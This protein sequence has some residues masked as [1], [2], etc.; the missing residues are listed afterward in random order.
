MADV[1]TLLSSVHGRDRRALRQI[2]K[3][4][5]R[6]AVQYGSR[7]LQNHGY[8]PRYRYTFANIVYITDISSRREITSYVLPMHKV[9]VS[10]LDERIHKE[11]AESL[12]TLPHSSTS[13]CILIVDQSGSMRTCDVV[14]HKTRSD[15]VFGCIALDL[16]GRQI[17]QAGT[18]LT[19]AVTLIEMR[20]KAT[21]VFE[22]EPMTNVLFNKML[23]QKKE[24][25]PS[26]HGNYVPALQEAARVM[27]DDKGNS[28][29]ALLL[30][31]LSDGKPSDKGGRE[32]VME[33]LK[34]S[35]QEL[36]G[37]FGAQ[38]TFGMIGFGGGEADFGVLQSMAEAA[39]EAGSH[40]TFS[41]SG[42]CSQALSNT[43]SSLG[44]R[45]SATRT[46][47]TALT[48]L[49][50]P[51]AGRTQR[52]ARRALPPPGRSVWRG[53]NRGWVFADVE[54]CDGVALQIQELGRGAER[55][56]YEFRHYQHSPSS[57]GPLPVGDCLV[58]K[59]SAFVEDDSLKKEFHYIF[60]KTQQQAGWFARHF[61]RRVAE[62]CA[63]RGWLVPA[64]I[65]FQQCSV[66]E[67]TTDNPDDYLAVLVEK[68]LD[69]SKWVKWNTNHGHVH[70]GHEGGSQHKMAA[71][72]AGGGNAL[73]AVIAGDLSYVD[74]SQPKMPVILEDS[75]SECEHDDV[76][77]SA[78]QAGAVRPNLQPAP[79]SAADLPQC[80]SHYTYRISQ[81]K[82]LVCD[83]QGTLDESVSPAVFELTDPVIHHASVRRQGVYGRTDHGK[84]GMHTF[85]QSHKCN[86]LCGLLW[87]PR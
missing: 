80:S 11:A 65:T 78:A 58:A 22:R 70:H 82:S 87:L 14:D 13:H 40:A 6:A 48:A 4:D 60:C 8:T 81:R 45:L 62:T 83:L 52:P 12:L 37:E 5:L 68:M 17:D 66:Y 34:E 41:Y 69:Q 59:E 86:A 84:K 16:L 57:S 38:L 21:T 49:S 30:L 73:H 36:A 35:I 19:D 44:S 42:Q 2:G 1:P 61:N 53:K 64:T 27:A 10:Q 31:F 28:K 71:A 85:F 55:V 3:R 15:A 74:V 63:Q 75:D 72:A 79:F 23:R 43:I 25:T 24:A 46:R 20:D 33:S 18:A 54:P 76:E 26:H 51:Q 56:V 39:T 29:C 47:I 32:V 67:L 50:G 7:E 77:D 9:P